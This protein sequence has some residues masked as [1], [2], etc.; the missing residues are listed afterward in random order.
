LWDAAREIFLKNRLAA[1]VVDCRPQAPSKLVGRKLVAHSHNGGQESHSSTPHEDAAGAVGALSLQARS[2]PES[3]RQHRANVSVIGTGL[4]ALAVSLELSRG[5]VLEDV[6]T[7]DRARHE[8]GLKACRTGSFGGAKGGSRG[9]VGHILVRAAVTKYVI[10]CRGTV[11][12]QEHSSRMLTAR[13]KR[14]EAHAG[15]LA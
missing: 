2:V 11:A 6:S 10:I 13:K 8:A 14:C 9:G 4:V 7:P 3:M 5:D 12:E 1:F 15:R